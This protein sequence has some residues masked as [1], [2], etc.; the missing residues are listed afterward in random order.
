MLAILA[1]RS[2]KM[3]GSTPSIE[4]MVNHRSLSVAA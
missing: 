2:G 1:L 3:A 4:C